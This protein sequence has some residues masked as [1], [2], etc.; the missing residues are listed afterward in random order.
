MNLFQTSEP[1]T[2]HSGGRTCFKIECDA[3]TKGDCLTVANWMIPALPRF[4]SVE[5]VASTGPVS[6]WLAEGFLH[7]TSTVGPVLI[8]DDVL[9]T[10]ASMEEQRGGRNAC[11]VVI[12][13]RGVCP[14]WISAFM[15][16]NRKLV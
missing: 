8:C 12:F 9:T 2:L 1:F 10:G 5:A 3:L 16:M 11:G 13:A 6:K 15:T 7:F 14:D 4:S